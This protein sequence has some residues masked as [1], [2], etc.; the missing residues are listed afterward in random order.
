MRYKGKVHV[1][2]HLLHLSPYRIIFVE[3]L[4]SCYVNY[5]SLSRLRK[6]RSGRNRSPK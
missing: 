5:V 3:D 1:M 2:W 4:L 6:R